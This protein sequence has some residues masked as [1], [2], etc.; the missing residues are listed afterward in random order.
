[1]PRT[2]RPLAA[3]AA[4]L[5]LVSTAAAQKPFDDP[6]LERIRKD[7]FF[8]ASPECEGRGIETKGIQLAADHIAE[9]FK[10]AGLK[11]AMKDGT[12]FQPFEVQIERLLNRPVSLVLDGPGG[13]ALAHGSEFT[14]MGYS[15][16]GKAQGNLV[17]AG[18]GITAP[19]LK[20]DDYAGLDVKG[21]VVVVLR[22][23]PRY[24]EK[25][26]KRFDT[27]VKANEDSPHAAFAAKIALAEKNKAAAL[28]IVNDAT[29]PFDQLAP[30]G[31]HASGTTEATIPVLMVKRFAFDEVLKANKL[32]PI[33]K[34]EKGINETLKPNS[35][36][37]KGW[38]ASS[39]VTVVPSKKVMCKNVIGV[40]EGKGPLKDETVV[41]GA[42]YDHVGYGLW[43]SNGGEKAAGQIH[44]GADD[45][46]S[47]TTGLME[48]ARRFGAI[49]NREGRRIVFVAFSGEEHGL[50][51]SRFYCKEP[52]FPLDKTTTM[53]N[54]D[55]IG[56]TKPVNIDWLGLFGQKDKLIVYGQGTGDYFPALVEETGKKAELRLFN[57]KAS[58]TNSDN[59]SF[60]MKK[61]PVLFFFTGLHAEYHRPADKPETINVPGLKK[62]VDMVEAVAK[63]V[64]TRETPPKYAVVSDRAPLD[65]SNPTP[66]P[67]PSGSGGPK[68]PRLGVMPSYSFEG[69]GLL[70]EGVTP[71]SAADKA[72]LKDGDIIVEIGGKPVSNVTTYMGVMAAQKLGTTI[73]IVVERNGKKVKLK[74]EL[75]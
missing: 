11:P 71:G 44:N 64:T 46:G 50:D 54:L 47:G 49:K 1:M 6:V 60:Y 13:R 41:I 12:Y 22:R 16:T 4:A 32:D 30:F 74:A 35:F 42:H 53:L 26:D 2:F 48:L 39:E 65:P 29:D 55:M 40:L 36:E 5:A 8:L 34:I 66:A 15:P 21:K 24:G 58:A 14:A 20:Y 72:G 38:S 69:S 62:V 31:A 18:F 7:I 25:G 56:R 63:E 45:N 73:E 33:A 61:V 67:S 51:G 27:G 10:A 75:K 23:T 19:D 52:L 59:H 3:L 37:L 28:I 9:T 57:V 43:G 17:F 68:G 70:L